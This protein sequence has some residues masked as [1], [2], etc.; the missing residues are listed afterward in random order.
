MRVT[1]ATADRIAAITPS[2]HKASVR[3]VRFGRSGIG[4]SR[5][6]E[7][8]STW[9]TSV[10]NCVEMGMSA[11]ARRLISSPVALASQGRPR[12]AAVEL[13]LEQSGNVFGIEHGLGGDVSRKDIH[14]PHRL[15]S[16]LSNPRIDGH[17]RCRLLQAGRSDRVVENWHGS[18]AKCRLVRAQSGLEHL[19]RS[20]KSLTERVGQ[21]LRAQKRVPDAQPGKR[22]AVIGGITHKSPAWSKTAPIKIRQL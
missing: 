14:E 19:G 8:V 10:A 11:S 16:G 3:T 18:V 2:T 15:L 6:A 9:Q 7:D 12:T 13:L 4:A 5:E 1:S 20:A 22:V 21:Q 17:C